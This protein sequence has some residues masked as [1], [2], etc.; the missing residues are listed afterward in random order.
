MMGDVLID[1]HAKH[2]NAWAE[3]PGRRS[4]LW[5]MPWNLDEELKPNV[6]SVSNPNQ[7]FDRLEWIVNGIH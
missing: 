7:L 4:I 2:V 1:D 6:F 5:C 3:N